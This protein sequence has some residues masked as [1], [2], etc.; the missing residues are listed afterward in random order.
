M[1]RACCALTRSRLMPRGWLND[2]RI[3]PLVISLKVTRRRSD[4]GISSASARCQ[5][6][7]S[8]S[9]SRSVASQTASAPLAARRMSA[10]RPSFSSMIS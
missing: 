5:A 7:A 9:R 10:S 2:S 8:P 1:R 4:S 6:I 3:A